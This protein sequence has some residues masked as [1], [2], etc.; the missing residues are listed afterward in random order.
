MSGMPPPPSSRGS[1]PARSGLSMPESWDARHSDGAAP[2]VKPQPPPPPKRSRG[3][4]GSKTV[5]AVAAVLGVTAAAGYA[6]WELSKPVGEDRAPAPAASTSGEPSAQPAGSSAAL[7]SASASAASSAPSASAV[8]RKRREPP[9]DVTACFAELLPDDAFRDTKPELDKL[10][11]GP[12]AYRTML[13]LKGAMV[14]AGKRDVTEAMSEWSK[15]GWYETAAFVV[16]RAHC[17][18]DAPAPKAYKDVEKCRYEESLAWLTNAL[19]DRHSMTKAVRAHTESIN[20]IVSKGLADQF[21]RGG[22]PY[23]GELVY[24]DRI[25]QRIRKAR[26]R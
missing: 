20:C 24:F 3:G 10:C 4:S 17:C 2:R 25:L 15:L 14:A 1:Q 19:D 11:T 21:G 8:T 7:A 6:A 18:P 16:M 26:D 23:G 5:L 9:A 12:K 13:E 22:L